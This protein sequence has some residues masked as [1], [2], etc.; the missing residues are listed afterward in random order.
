MH[1]LVVFSGSNQPNFYDDIKQELEMM[2]QSIDISKFVIWYGGGEEGIMS[3]LPSAFHKKGGKVCSIDWEYFV[4]NYGSA[5]FSTNYVMDTFEKRQAS[6]IQKGDVYLCLPGGVGT[7]SELF[8][9]LVYNDVHKKDKKIILFSFRDFFHPIQHFLQEK[10]EQGFIKPRNL[11]NII[12]VTEWKDVI[13]VLN[14][15]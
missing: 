7:L 3:V 1:N 10:T 11:K 5:S 14:E 12:I 15:F 9:V 6:L 4:K 2:A 8:D 13:R